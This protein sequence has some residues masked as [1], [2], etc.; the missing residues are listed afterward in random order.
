M[1]NLNASSGMLERAA[2]HAKAVSATDRIGIG[3]IGLGTVG[4]GVFKILSE[5]PE[6]FFSK[7]SVR[8]MGKARNLPGLDAA[9]L[10]QDPF[11]VV[12][13][14]QVQVVIEVMGGSELARE[15]VTEALQRGKHVVTAN[16]ELIAKHGPQLF[17]I[18][19]ANNVRLMLEG[20]VAGGIPI[21]MPLKLSLSA[22]RILEIA[23]ILNG[24]TNY[25]LTKMTREGMEYETALAQAQALGFAEADPTND[26]EGFDTAYKISILS[27]IA[28]KQRIDMNH[29]YRKG[30]SS[31][32]ATDIQTA[33]TLGYT[34]KLIGLSRPAEEGK[35]DI[36]VHPMLVPHQHPLA[37]ISFENNAIWIKGDAVGEV[38]FYG[39]GAGEL[40]TASAVTADVLAITTSLLKG[41]DPIPEMHF[42]YETDANLLPVTETLSRYYLRIH[43][44]DW[45]GVIGSLGNACGEAGVS[46][47]SVFQR[48][49]NVDGTSTI[50][51]ITHEVYEKQL[52]KAMDTILS[53]ESTQNI[54]CVL[55]V[56]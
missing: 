55:R 43:T 19:K 30:I 5:H 40:P 51:L 50:V 16:K 9:C 38:M 49:T 39:K 52:R 10:T 53:Q 17:Q 33:D 6:L 36:R 13:D 41:N 54:G 15:I 31:I 45:V 20:A 32:T 11:A 2:A 26:V 28:Y 8:D 29:I 23:G 46:L 21:I 48:S 42:E 12:R 4:T 22:N 25:I 14:E 24:T 1:S 56:L 18:A 35:V 7:I 34:I 27:S 44:Y 3:M 37:Q 47:E